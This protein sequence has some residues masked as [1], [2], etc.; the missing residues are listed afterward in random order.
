MTPDYLRPRFIYLDNVGAYRLS[1]YEN[2]VV[3]PEPQ[4][5]YLS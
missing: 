3:L 4:T 2:K 5:D 1:S